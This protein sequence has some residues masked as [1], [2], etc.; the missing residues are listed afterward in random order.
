MNSP[1]DAEGRDLYKCKCVTQY[2]YIHADAN[3]S[4]VN[5]QTISGAFRNE[6]NKREKLN[7]LLPLAPAQPA[8]LWCRVSYQ[9]M[10]YRT[11][12]VITGNIV[13]IFHIK[14]KLLKHI[15]NMFIHLD[16]HNC[17]QACTFK[18][19]DKNN[20]RYFFEHS[21]TDLD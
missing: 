19:C 8:R 11:F 17:M 15:H 5:Q 21:S 14:D 10:H 9:S 2:T 4:K 20:I 18:Y 13:H 16:K 7:A 1:C 3:Y 12:I 6:T